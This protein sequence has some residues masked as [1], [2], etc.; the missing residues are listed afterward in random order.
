MRSKISVLFP[1]QR[2]IDAS[3]DFPDGF[4][5]WTIR[6][7]VFTEFADR[8]Y[9]GADVSNAESTFQYKFDRFPTELEETN[10]ISRDTYE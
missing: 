6:R 9:Y 8:I 7:P 4:G 3:F 5:Q 1:R 2:E 10:M